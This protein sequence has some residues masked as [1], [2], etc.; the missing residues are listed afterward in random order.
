MRWVIKQLAGQA[1]SVERLKRL[2]KHP[3]CKVCQLDLLKGFLPSH[4]MQAGFEIS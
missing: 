3:L 2:I 4:Q 1:G